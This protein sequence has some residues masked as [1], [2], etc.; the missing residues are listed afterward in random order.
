M[1]QGCWGFG[2]SGNQLLKHLCNANST[3]TLHV[4]QAMKDWGLET[5]SGLH[6][7]SMRTAAYHTIA[8]LPDAQQAEVKCTTQAEYIIF[9]NSAVFFAF[10]QPDHHSVHPILMVVAVTSHALHF[11]RS[12]LIGVQGNRRLLHNIKSAGQSGQAIER[13]QL[14]NRCT[15]P[16]CPLT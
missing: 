13:S 16:L 3:Q 8:E 12:F 4:P 14:L 15:S 9:R 1:T 5:R 10:W 6:G 7:S 11:T 2:Q